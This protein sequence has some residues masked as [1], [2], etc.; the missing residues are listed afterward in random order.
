M[1]SEA[2]GRHR[3]VSLHRVAVGLCLAA[4]GAACDGTPAVVLVDA[5]V[6]VDADSTLPPTFMWHIDPSSIG[7]FGSVPAEADAGSTSDVSPPACPSPDESSFCADCYRWDDGGPDS[8][9]RNTPGDAFGFVS[10]G[11]FNGDGYDDVAVGAPGDL[12]HALLPEDDWEHGVGIGEGAVYVFL[13]SDHGLLPWRT[14]RPPFGLAAFGRGAA[15]GDFDGDGVADLAVASSVF[16][17]VIEETVGRIDVYRGTATGLEPFTSFRSVDVLNDA[18]EELRSASFGDA[19]LARDLDTFDGVDEL[20]VGTPDYIFGGAIV[21]WRPS[22]ATFGFVSAYGLGLGNDERFGAA[23]GLRETELLVGA[24]GADT[25]Y[26]LARED[27][28]IIVGSWTGSTGFGATIATHD[29]HALIGNEVDGDV[30]GENFAASGGVVRPIAIVEPDADGWYV[31]IAVEDIPGNV[32]ALRISPDPGI[33]ID[34]QSLPTRVADDE[35]GV[36]TAIG[37]SDADGI[38]DLWLGAPARGST[39]SAGQVIGYRGVYQPHDPDYYYSEEVNNHVL[40]DDEHVVFDQELAACDRCRV[41]SLDDGEP[42]ADGVCVELDCTELTGCGDGWPNAGP[43]PSREH[44]DDHNT[45][46][47]DACSST[48]EPTAFVIA[49]R[50]SRVDAPGSSRTIAL[51]ETGAALVVWTAEL[52]A[53]TEVRA[54]RYTRYGVE[55]DGGEDAT[56]IR[57]ASMPGPGWDPQPVAVGLPGGGWRV[58]WT[59][60]TGAEASAVALR[61]VAVDGS[62]SPTIQPSAGSVHAADP[63]LL[64]FDG[65]AA[66]LWTDATDARSPRAM[67]QALD[68]AG[69]PAGTPVSLDTRA[70]AGAAV[71]MT[72]DGALVAWVRAPEALG[73]RSHIVGMRFGDGPIDATPFEIGTGIGPITVASDAAG[74]AVA[75][76]GHAFD[77]AGDIYVRRVPVAGPPT[78]HSETRVTGRSAN[79]RPHIEQRPSIAFRSDGWIVGW[80]EPTEGRVRLQAEVALPAE[81]EMYLESQL[82]GGA[83]RDLSLTGSSRGTWV[84]W[85]DARADL[86]PT[87]ARSTRGFILHAY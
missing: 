64:A 56:P 57:I 32:S 62:L 44:C 79:G 18:G 12:E 58:A 14:I 46:D 13:G 28:S 84:I 70:S 16:D 41:F 19:M 37:D 45:S 55:V 4:F 86:S 21:V 2:R 26:R 7:Q 1:A 29:E 85:S 8:L 10:T 83:Q 48:C 50:E 75:W 87:P 17:D 51:D 74:F 73:D 20:V 60:P 72:A 33:V 82:V 54:R 67:F 53:A 78:V 80:E 11:D 6:P 43:S 38:P 61:N 71:A 40:F 9:A 23:L 42:C 24:P 39:E 35:L 63:A 76:T 31:A 5:S 36:A 22:D 66:V 34:A 65:G 47:G 3:S 69:R 49:S 52:D 30:G 81:Y 68:G 15:A 27:L 59:Q 77:A 25:V